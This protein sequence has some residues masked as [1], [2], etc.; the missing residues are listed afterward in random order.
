MSF[1]FLTEQNNKR[2]SI[3][4]GRATRIKRQLLKL[5]KTNS[6]SAK[7]SYLPPHRPWELFRRTTRANIAELHYTERGVLT[8]EGLS[9][10]L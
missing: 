6:K 5:S 4:P 9:N 1:I 8:R 2:V 10:L 7:H 3:Q